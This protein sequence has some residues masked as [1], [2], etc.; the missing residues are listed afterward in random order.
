[1]FTEKIKNGINVVKACLVA[2]G[3]EGRKINQ[4]TDSPTWNQQL[5]R[6]VFVTAPAAVWKISSTDI[7][8]KFLQGDA[9]NMY[10]CNLHQN[11]VIQAKFGN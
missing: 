9:I 3:F 7:T 11:S 1:M 2:R 6:M 4:K 5:L 10:T 8:S